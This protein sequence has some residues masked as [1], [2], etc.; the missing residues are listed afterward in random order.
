MKMTLHYVFMVGHCEY[1][2]FYDEHYGEDMDYD[3]ELTEDEIEEVAID[4]V[5]NDTGL[6]EESAKKVV[7][8]VLEDGGLLEPYLESYRDA[9][10]DYFY[11][12][13]HD[14]FYDC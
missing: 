11:D 4:L 14:A 5:M 9:I 12:R 13:A 7:R 10:K 8:G 1:D 6:D 2:S 3:Y